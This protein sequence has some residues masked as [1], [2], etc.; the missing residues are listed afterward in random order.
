METWKD[1]VGKWVVALVS[2]GLDSTTIVKWLS[3]RGV[4]VLALTVDLGQPDESDMEDI[5]RRMKAAG[6][7]EAILIDGKNR[8]AK[9]AMKV[10]HAQAFHEG[11]Y[12]NTTGIARMSAV[13]VALSEI[14][15]REIKTVVHGATGRGNDQVRFEL[16]FA[17]LDP[18]IQIYAP[19]RKRDFL[20][21]FGGRREM[22]E[23]CQNHCLE[24]STTIKKPY[25]TD[26]N[27]CGLTHEAGKLE[28]LNTPTDFVNFIMCVHPKDAPDKEE[29]VL[30]VFENGVPVGINGHGLDLVNIFLE[31]NKIAGRN[32]VGILDVVE[33]RRVGIKSRGIYEAPGVTLLGRAYA[34]MLELILD[35]ER[36][37][38]FEII[39]RKLADVVYEGEWFSPLASDLLAVTE[40]IAKMVTGVVVFKLY[41][42]N[43][44]FA[45]ADARHSLYD[46]ERSSME[47]IGEFN[48]EDSQGYLNI[49][50]VTAR[51]M[52]HA[53]LA[54][55]S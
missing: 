30:I 31:L 10:I 39:S 15:K 55:K 22:I 53:G 16:G 8:L 54:H 4:R 17:M 44:F 5:P 20:K 52:A 23:Y 32:G 12:W 11:G 40:N 2:G 34:K 13:S 28:F 14:Q 26:S 37:K 51:A 27:L 38:S 35:R 41:K 19:W 24:V 36:R 6:A 33:N 46:P 45:S 18:K 49:A 50:G 9:D 42:G 29:T 1:L 43:I 25:S 48:H 21:E 47:K 3:S 7:E